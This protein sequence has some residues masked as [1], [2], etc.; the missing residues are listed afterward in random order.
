MSLNVQKVLKNLNKLG[1]GETAA[2][3]H[4]VGKPMAQCNTGA[5]QV[6]YRVAPVVST[7]EEAQLFAV[8]CIYCLWREAKGEPVQ[9]E[10]WIGRMLRDG[11]LTPSAGNR[12]AAL[13]D[14]RWEEQALFLTKLGH[15]VNMLKSKGMDRPDCEALFYDLM[16][17][18]DENQPVQ[19]KWAKTIYSGYP[20]FDPAT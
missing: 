12:V 17:W 8:C 9:T 14:L 10:Y 2:L 4:C 11:T 20:A 16:N 18:D 7:E 1:T 6:F 19:R 13:I 5:L 15:L 3:R